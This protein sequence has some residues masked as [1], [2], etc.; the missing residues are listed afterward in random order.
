MLYVKR[1]ATGEYEDFSFNPKPGFQVTS[2]EDPELKAWLQKPGNQNLINK[3]LKRLDLEMVRTMEDLIEVLIEKG[4]LLFT[5]LPEP[6]QNKILFKRSLR[7]LKSQTY[8][9]IHEDDNDLLF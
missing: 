6:V 8:S 1:N 7:N 4:L 3:T 9:I 2:F 5:D